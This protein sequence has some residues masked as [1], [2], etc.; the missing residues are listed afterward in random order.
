MLHAMRRLAVLVAFLVLAV[1]ASADAKR[2]VRYDITGGLAPA[3]E[4]LVVNTNGHARQTGRAG[5]RSF[6]LTAKQL[7]GLE[8]D[9]RKARFNSLKRSYQPEFPVMDGQTHMVSYRGRSIAVYAEAKVPKR[10][11]RVLRRLARLMN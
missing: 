3:S 5:V 11:S 9:L 10:L 6:K 8:T 2:L 1:P 7:S 4:S